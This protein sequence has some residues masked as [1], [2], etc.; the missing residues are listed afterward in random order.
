MDCKSF[1][2][3]VITLKRSQASKILEEGSTTILFRSRIQVIFIS[4]KFSK[5]FGNNING[6]LKGKF[7]NNL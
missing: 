2:Y 4:E 7:A 3:W 5:L 1:K 6:N